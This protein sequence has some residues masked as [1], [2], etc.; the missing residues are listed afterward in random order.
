[1]TTFPTLYKRTSTGAI[2]AWTIGVEKSTI[3][4]I[5][6]QTDGKK[7]TT[8]DVIREGK[9]VGRSNETT[10]AEQA[11]AEA[12][13]KWEGKIKKGY[14]E[15]VARAGAGE[16][17][18]DG[19]YDCMLAHK[20]AD[21][22][23]KIKYPAYIQPK[24]NGH[25]CLAI[26]EDGVCTL[27]SRTRKPITSMPHIIEELQ[28]A[29]K[30]GHHELDG[31]LYNHSFKDGFEHIASLIRQEVPKPNCTDVEYHVYDKRMAGGFE[32][33]IECLVN[34]LLRGVELSG[35][36]KAPWKYVKPTT[37]EY[38]SSEEEML[39]KFESYLKAGY[40][41]GMA[42]NT[43]G[44]YVGKRS[45]DLQ[46]IKEFQDDEFKIVGIKEGRGGYAGCGIFVCEAKNGDTFDVKMRGPKE[47]LM[48]FLSNP[49]TWKGKM[50]TVKYQYISAYGI[51]IFPVGER[52]A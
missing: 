17:D 13:S 11:L 5:H 30:T 51:P 38:I 44:L 29:F 14:V 25:R 48:E 43:N 46:K 10:P 22:G 24:L 47:R 21:H 6:G 52:F 26:I 23:H 8:Q 19:G 36:N 18:I 41:G 7:Q 32:K 35:G 50:L 27:W 31:E 39:E 49:S 15:D 33:R 42:R 45:Y 34:D 3:I 40:E 2:Q 4:T 28:D 16:K 20:F 12:T 9:N 37:T 1:M